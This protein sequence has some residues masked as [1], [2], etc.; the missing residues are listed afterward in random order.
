MRN[1]DTGKLAC[2]ACFLS[3]TRVATQGSQSLSRPAGG[4]GDRG[5]SLLVTS[6]QIIEK[7]H[8]FAL[9]ANS[10]L[11]VSLAAF[12]NHKQSLCLGLNRLF[13]LLNEQN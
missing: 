3:V 11:I 5:A 4:R 13:N 6:R 1:T 8:S 10:S 9:R 7:R 12:A 2:S